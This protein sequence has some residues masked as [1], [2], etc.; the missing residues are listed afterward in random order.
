MSPARSRARSATLRRTLLRSI[1]KVLRHASNARDAA[2]TAAVQI[3]AGRMG[4]RANDL[5]RGR[6]PDVLLTPP[7]TG[8]E[9]PVDVEA[10]GRIVAV[11]Y[12]SREDKA[13][14]RGALHS[15]A[16][17]G[18][19]ALF[20]VWFEG[21]FKSCSLFFSC[22]MRSAVGPLAFARSRSIGLTCRGYRPRSTHLRPSNRIAAF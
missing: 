14:H 11:H 10:G 3:L 8:Q 22:D 19:S 2:A 6:I 13:G 18:R 20:A 12:G 16:K 1:G 7:S 4:E 9:F 21:R 17:C 5:A 15:L